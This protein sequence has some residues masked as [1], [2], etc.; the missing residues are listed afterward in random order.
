MCNLCDHI[1]GISYSSKE[2]FARAGRLVTFDLLRDIILDDIPT[3]ILLQHQKVNVS[4]FAI[5]GA[6]DNEEK[7]KSHNQT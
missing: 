5:S 7:S 4:F 1:S 3:R 6:E 2:S